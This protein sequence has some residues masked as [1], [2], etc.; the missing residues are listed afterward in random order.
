MQRN[1]AGTLYVV[2]TPL[3]NLE[4]MTLRAIRVLKEVSLI[5]AEDTRRSR[6]LLTHFDIHTPSISYF[7]QV[8]ERKAPRLVQRLREGQSVALISDA[9]TP[10]ISD[11]GF[12]LIRAA[13]EAGIRVVPVPGPSV[14]VAALSVAGLPTDRFAFEGFVPSRPGARRAFFA[15]LRGERRTVV[16]FEAGRRLI[17][18]LSVLRDVLGAREVVVAREVTKLFEQF[19]RGDVSDVL[20]RL[21]VQP[22]RGEV[23]LLIGPAVESGEARVAEPGQSTVEDDMR[24]ALERL[25]AEGL[26]LKESARQLAKQRGWSRRE[27]YQAGLELQRQHDDAAG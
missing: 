19:E 17:A 10:G 9:G 6:T 20:S 4:D 25:L 16:C 14:I 23:T 8:E 12:R 21:G 15:G 13:I 2:A 26:S 22:V 24:S 7:D 18:S 27:I 1:M 11:P 5:A 3:G